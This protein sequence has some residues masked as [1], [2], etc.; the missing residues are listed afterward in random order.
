MALPLLLSLPPL[1]GAS[2]LHSIHDQSSSTA[3]SSKYSGIEPKQQ[4]AFQTR[5]E[6]ER[7]RGHRLPLPN[8]HQR[9][10]YSNASPSPPRRP[11]VHVQVHLLIFHRASLRPP[12]RQRPL[13]SPCDR[14]WVLRLVLEG[15]F[16]LRVT[17]DHSVRTVPGP[18]KEE[19]RAGHAV[20]DTVNP[21]KTIDIPRGKQ[22]C[23]TEGGPGQ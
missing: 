17:A 9:H 23:G 5:T 3:S 19:N 11:P 21:V 10:C 15:R 1:P 14:V 4:E 16:Q 18:R 13:S 2:P 22:L 12:P 20:E 6:G 8:P 7:Q